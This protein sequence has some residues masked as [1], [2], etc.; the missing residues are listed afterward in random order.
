MFLSEEIHIFRFCLRR[1]LYLQVAFRRKSNILVSLRRRKPRI[2][3]K[4][5]F[6]GCIEK[7]ITVFS[8]FGEETAVSV[9]FIG[10][11]EKKIDLQVAMSRKP[12][13]LGYIEE[14]TAF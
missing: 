9:C 5:T 3:V 11:F 13:L 14:E 1:K 8:S 2:C 10:S 4:I 6:S 12:Y 7:I